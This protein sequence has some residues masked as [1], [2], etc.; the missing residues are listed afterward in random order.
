LYII[1]VYYYLKRAVF[2]AAEAHELFVEADG[3]HGLNAKGQG[4]AGLISQKVLLK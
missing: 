3:H 4:R 1:S 2:V